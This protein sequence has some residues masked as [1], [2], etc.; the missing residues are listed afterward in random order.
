MRPQHLL[1]FAL[2]VLFVPSHAAES[3]ADAKLREALRATTLQLRNVEA[4]RANLQTAQTA[5]AEENKTL[6]AR[7]ETLKKEF[8]GERAVIDKTVADLKAQLAAREAEFAQSRAA[9]EKWEAS[10][11]EAA[12][13]ATAK[14]TDRAKLAA[15]VAVLQRLVADRE[16]KNV[17]LYKLAH[18][19]LTRYEKFSLG[20]ALAAR[21]PFV[22]ATRTKL[23]NLV[24]DYQD[25]LGEQRVKP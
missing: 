20:E 11:K 18:E 19:I 13:L 4:E 21:E 7:V 10:Q 15:E 17:A 8:A 14:E 6:A 5:L 24:Q 23:E 16:A 2:A 25:K 1:P 22:G 12:A 3:A 9:A